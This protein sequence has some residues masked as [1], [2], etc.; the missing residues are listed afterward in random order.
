META[1]ATESLSDRPA[2]RRLRK[3]IRDSDGD[4]AVSGRDEVENIP[5]APVVNIPTVIEVPVENAHSSDAP[6]TTVSARP[7]PDAAVTEADAVDAD[8]EMS[9][10]N[11]PGNT[12][13]KVLSLGKSI[14]P[15]TKKPKSYLLH[16]LC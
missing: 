1:N 16:V 4:E 15:A 13:P 11:E 3:R 5:S 6:S 12:E 9:G 14:Q 7:V 2:L 8:D 10:A